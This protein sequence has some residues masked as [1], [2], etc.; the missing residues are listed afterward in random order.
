MSFRFRHAICNEV[1]K[2]WDFRQAC[3]S[4][5]KAGYTGIEIA[6]FTLGPDPAALTDA[7]RAELRDIV[8]FAPPAGDSGLCVC[9]L[10]YA[11][12]MRLSVVCDAA[13][14]EEPEGFLREVVARLVRGTKVKILGKQNDWYKIEAN[15]KAG[16][17]YRGAIGL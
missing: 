3:Q 1:Y 17:V 5:R 11:G 4:I 13:T 15:G 2:G 6:P 14:L 10:S 8:V 7:K 12:R 9:A 16:W